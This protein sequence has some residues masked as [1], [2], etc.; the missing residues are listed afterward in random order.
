MAAEH[1]D[2]GG[3]IDIVRMSLGV[4]IQEVECARVEG[5][6]GKLVSKSKCLPGTPPAWFPVQ[7]SLVAIPS[8]TVAIHLH[9]IHIFL[10]GTCTAI[11]AL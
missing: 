5:M 10:C 7:A 9:T 6:F 2:V 3:M 4:V 11:N 1:R 8:A